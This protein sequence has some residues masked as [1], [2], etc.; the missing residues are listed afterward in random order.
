MLISLVSR[1]SPKLQNKKYKDIKRCLN[2]D[3]SIF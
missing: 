2:D 1:I 3:N